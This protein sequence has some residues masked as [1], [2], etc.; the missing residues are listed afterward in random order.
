M[1]KR[2]PLKLKPIFAE[3]TSTPKDVVVEEVDDE[4]PVMKLRLKAQSFNN[5]YMAAKQ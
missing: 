4:V 5:R 1:K 3:A 2:R